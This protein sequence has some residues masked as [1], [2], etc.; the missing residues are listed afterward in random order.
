MLENLGSASIVVSLLSF[1]L[2]LP[3][4]KVTLATRLL[5]R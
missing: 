3:A 1:F 2:I 5:P 4:A